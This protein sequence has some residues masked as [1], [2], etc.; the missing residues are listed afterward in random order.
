MIESLCAA[1][2]A[3]EKRCIP[4]CLPRSLLIA[5]GHTGRWQVPTRDEELLYLNTEIEKLERCLGGYEDRTLPGEKRSPS[6][7]RTIEQKQ[8]S[9]AERD[10]LLGITQAPS[11][12]SAV[13]ELGLSRAGPNSTQIPPD[14]PPYYPNDLKPQTHLIIAEAVRKFPDQTQT[15]ELC[16][17]IISDLT[18]H[19]RAA[20]LGKTLRADLVFP[21]M[22]ELL[23]FSLVSN[24][25]NDDKRFRLKQEVRQ[26]DEWLNLAREVADSQRDSSESKHSTPK[27][28]LK[29]TINSPSAARRME[30]FLECKG[31]GQ[32]DFASSVGTTDR[33]LR[34][35]RKTGKV[36][37]DIFDSIAKK[38]NI[39]KEELLKTE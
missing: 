5:G 17:Y 15:L 22:N 11:P 28:R 21:N 36:R 31:I 10:R 29:A 14:L 9:M 1:R 13:R 33:T 18:P 24:C 35:F 12:P 7:N 32:T 8:R 38:M 26:S 30:A 4:A 25:E 16:R 27:S 2:V 23:H 37:R 34:A 39:T 6:Y 19:F 20:V 3:P